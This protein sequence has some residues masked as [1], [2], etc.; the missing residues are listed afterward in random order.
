MSVIQSIQSL[1]NTANVSRNNETASGLK[2]FRFVDVAERNDLLRAQNRLLRL[3][4]SLESLAEVA[5]V[6]TRFRFDIT[7][8]RSSAGLGLD[9][10]HTAATLASRVFISSVNLRSKQAVR[11]LS[12]WPLMTS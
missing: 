12:T 11:L 1:A 8:A 3:Y 9:L 5:D 2:P 10:T 6:K 7:D 4:R